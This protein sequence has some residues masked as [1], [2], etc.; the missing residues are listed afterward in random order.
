M[1]SPFIALV[2]SAVYSLFRGEATEHDL[3]DAG[4]KGG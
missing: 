2:Q 1:N 3:A 4:H